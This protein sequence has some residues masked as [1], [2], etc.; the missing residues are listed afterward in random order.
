MEL[1]FMLCSGNERTLDMSDAARHLL[2]TIGDR[3][4]A[5]IL[6]DPPWQF[7]WGLL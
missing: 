5:T 3:R 1:L 4:F 6:A 2:S 7:T